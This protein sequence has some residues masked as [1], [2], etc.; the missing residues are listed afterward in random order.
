MEG[1]R[2]GYGQQ[3]VLDRLALRIDPDD[4]IA[5]LGANGNGKSTF[6]KLVAGRLS[7]MQGEIV[8][9]RALRVG[10]FAQHQIEDL[11]PDR[12]AI[13]HIQA[14]RPDEPVQAS[15]EWLARYGLGSE[16]A[17]TLARNLSGGEKT[18]LTMA[19]M[20]LDRPNLLILDEPTNHLDIDSRDA[21][22]EALNDFAGAVILISHDRRLVETTA[23][24]LWLVAE[25]AVR[26]YE[27][28]VEDYRAMLLATARE[29]PAAPGP[30]GS[31]LAGRL[32]AAERRARL[33]PLRKDAREAE[34]E[35]ERLTAERHRLEQ[36]LAKPQTYADGSDIAA[37]QRAAAE[38]A[39]AIAAAEGRW[40]EAEAAI[41]AIE[42]A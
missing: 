37:L 26:A 25:G 7:P 18:R 36:R 33:A 11:L 42:A 4:R 39:A 8:R 6:A 20:A 12:T 28:D 9:A 41:E 24:R 30:N 16:K 19:L 22:V 2:V 10:F 17:E 40:L 5:L 29:A 32:T 14:R 3:V 31:R 34:R 13:Q 1:V 21:L 27:G 35:V 38:L 15:R 23:D